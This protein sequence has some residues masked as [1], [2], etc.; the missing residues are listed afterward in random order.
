MDLKYVNV[1][2]R[3]IKGRSHDLSAE[4]VLI[5]KNRVEVILKRYDLLGGWNFKQMREHILD[6]N[7]DEI[8]VVAKGRNTWLDTIAGERS[9]V[10]M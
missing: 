4:L 6:R 8:L 10:K 9:L 7:A 5:I 3:L 2:T 1:A